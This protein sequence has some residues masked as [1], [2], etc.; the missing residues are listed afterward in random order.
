MLTLPPRLPRDIDRATMLRAGLRHDHRPPISFSAGNPDSIELDAS[1]PTIGLHMVW[2]GTYGTTNNSGSIDKNTWAALKNLDLRVDGDNSIVN[3]PG[4][5]IPIIS[6]AN[7]RWSNRE[8]PV[9]NGVGSDQDFR[10]HAFLPFDVG[11]YQSPLDLSV[12]QQNGL[13]VTWGKASDIAPDS[14]S[15]TPTLTGAQLEI[16]QLGIAGYPRG[17]QGGIGYPYR[18][19]ILNHV[20]RSVSQTGELTPNYQLKKNR[21][22]NAIYLIGERDSA[23]SDSV[24]TDVKPVVGNTTLL[25]FDFELL[26]DQNWHEYQLGSGE[27]TGVS[28]LD[29]T[30][31]GQLDQLQRVEGEATPELEIE[32]D[33]SSGTN[34]VHIIEDYFVDPVAA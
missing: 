14:S 5:A 3:I 23:F 32:A 31:N 17:S 26:R 2:K 15:G 8:T 16:T 24:V 18:R 25:N 13:N 7:Q 27:F 11:G 33:N 29:F 28:L 6:M 20:T 1:I 10:M 4:W 19:R 21:W 9:T 34:K 30:R 22:Y 12:H